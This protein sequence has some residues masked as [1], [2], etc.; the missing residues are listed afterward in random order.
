MTGFCLKVA[1]FL[2]FHE[3]LV[4]MKFDQLYQVI[5]LVCPPRKNIEPMKWKIAP[6]SNKVIV[7]S[8]IIIMTDEQ[9]LEQTKEILYFAFIK[10]STKTSYSKC[11]QEIGDV[12]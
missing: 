3:F 5:M 4:F 8:V 7:A 11:T 12:L 10:F 6:L 2:I 9:L 1:L